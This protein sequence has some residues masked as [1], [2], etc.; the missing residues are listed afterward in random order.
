VFF[1]SGIS[2][3]ARSRHLAT[4]VD[5]PSSCLYV[6]QRKLLS[7]TSLMSAASVRRQC[8]KR[9]EGRCGSYSRESGSG[10]PRASL[11]ENA[12]QALEINPPGVSLHTNCE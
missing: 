7:R 5:R 8:G 4:I 11:S 6:S 12:P 2:V 10:M 9:S 3:R 1:D